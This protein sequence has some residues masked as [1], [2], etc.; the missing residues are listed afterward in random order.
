MRNGRGIT[1]EPETLLEAYC[2]GVFPMTDADGRI[3]WYTADPRGVI[4][5]D[6]FHV[7][8]SLAQFMRGTSFPFEVRFDSDFEATMRACMAARRDRT[9]ISEPLI[10]AYVR[11]HALG[12]AH[13]VETWR[14][15]KRVGGL[16][17]VSIGGAFFGES[18]FHTQRDA[19]KVA[20]VRLVDRLRE[21]G[22]E[23]LDSQAATDHLRRFGCI[24]IPAA[25]YLRLLDKAIQ[26]DCS[27]V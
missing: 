20:L 8:R 15:G 4:P 16:Y 10:D 12:F 2:R 21:R 22:Y 1:L 7:P 6:R 27:F 14:E 13:S 19:S 17:G 3:R 9:W 18:M 11:L 25:R 24:E 5:L 23:L 26:K